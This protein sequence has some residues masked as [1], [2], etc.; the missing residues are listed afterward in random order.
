MHLHRLVAGAVA[1]A[2][3]RPRRQPQRRDTDDKVV[4]LLLHAYGMGGAIRSVFNLAE[5]LARR[6]DV[7]IV[8]VVREWQDPLLPLPPGVRVRWLDDRRRAERRSLTARVLSR[9][10]SVLLH[11]DD[12]FADWFTLWTDVLLLRR[13]RAVHSG[14]L[15]TTRP[16]FSAFAVRMARSSVVL[17]AQ[18]HTH[19]DALP[20]DLP[21]EVARSYVGCDAVVLLT[22]RDRTTYAALLAGAST[23]VVS[24]PNAV[25]RLP[26]LYC[27]RL[28]GGVR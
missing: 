17:V 24:I 4:L 8:S 22:E 19:L 13:V 12:D 7:E 20:G 21:A 28:T 11:P 3:R 1:R 27:R 10:P 16:A 14:V 2:L 6:L 15:I 9:F 25:P 18:E 26:A 23:K 5:E